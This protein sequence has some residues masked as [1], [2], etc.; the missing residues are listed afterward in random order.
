M[1]VENWGDVGVILRSNDRPSRKLTARL[2][3][4]AEAARGLDNVV[5]AAPGY[6]TLLLE[7]TS[8]HQKEVIGSISEVAEQ[9]MPFNG[10]SIEIPITYDGEDVAWACSHLKIT[11]EELAHA[12]SSKTYDVRLLGSPGFVYLSDVP[13]KLRLPRLDR[14]RLEV[15]AGTVGIG[16]RQTGI[17][18]RPRPGGWRLIG[19]VDE[20]PRLQPGDRVRFVPS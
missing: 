12:H 4:I 15:P 10:R 7:V 14:P 1:K 3:G 11:R 17:Y 20:V 9:A 16:G 6:T 19:R 8:G 13:A 2:A 18:G 5:D